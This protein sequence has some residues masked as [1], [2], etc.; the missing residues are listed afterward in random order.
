MYDLAEIVVKAGSGGSGAVSFRREKF[1]PFGGPDGGDGGS[2]GDV[3]ILADPGISSMRSF[4]NRRHFRAEDGRDGQGSRKH[5]RDGEDTVLR[6]PVGTA[7]K[8]K[9]QSGDVEI[10]ADL[11][12]PGQQVVAARG[13]RGGR[14][15][16]H[17]AS[18]T[19]QTPRI[20]QKGE[21][22][23]EK[24]LVLELRLIADV[25]IIGYPNVGKS[26]LLA[27][28][29]AARP[30]I[31]G[32]PFTTREPELGVAEVGQ[33]RFV[34][35]EIPGLIDG[36]HLGRGLGHEFLR[37][38]LR[39]KILIHLIDGSSESPLRDMIHVNKE[40]SLFESTMAQKPQIVAV[41]KID[42]PQVQARI[43]EIKGAF[44]SAGI[45]VFFVSAVNGDG[46][47]KLLAE[48]MKMLEEDKVKA[49]VGEKTPVK[50]FRPQP[51]SSRPV[52]SKD[53]DTFVLKAPAVER[54]I[55]GEGASTPVLNWQLKRQLDRMGV[56]RAL[57]KAGVKPGDR[58]RCGDI[59][60]EW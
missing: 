42:M 37:H 2:G 17:F 25:G 10:V 5:G 18:S 31:A 14:G 44:R 15:N 24:S 60:W 41:N 23:E 19:N 22:G 8:S 57:E 52:V 32:Y 38:A 13:G 58:V 50:V 1:V 16:T 9:I 6:V 49:S 30:R 48:A 55:S 20:A 27:A 7:V 12:K 51:R 29:S 28:A 53:G 11:D 39:T 26:T 34:L 40:L 21:D 46:V 45:E 3:V 56:S 43:E 59:E 47:G 54:I 36:A 33:E 35:A 4:R